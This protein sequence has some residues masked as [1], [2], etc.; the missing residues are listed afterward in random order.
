VS[1]VCT[2]NTFIN[3]SYMLKIMKI[4]AAHTKSY[5]NQRE[6]RHSDFCRIHQLKTGISYYG[7]KFFN[8]LPLTFPAI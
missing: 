5:E 2:K 3:V 7:P 6:Y 4:Y 8:L 1:I